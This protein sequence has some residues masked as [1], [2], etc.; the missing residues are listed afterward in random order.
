MGLDLGAALLGTP[1]ARQPAFPRPFEA[2]VSKVSGGQVFVA[3]TANPALAFGPCLGELA[4]G[5]AVGRQVLVVM[6]DGSVS[7]PWIIALA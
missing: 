4:V 1:R 5:L 2:K 6:I 3:P 7:R